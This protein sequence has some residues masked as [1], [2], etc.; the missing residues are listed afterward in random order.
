MRTGIGL[1][2]NSAPFDDWATNLTGAFSFSRYLL[3]S[4]TSSLYTD[5]G[6]GKIS[7]LN[8]QAGNARNFAQATAGN[9][10][11]LSTIGASSRA[12]ALFAASA[13]MNLA[14]AVAQSAF[15][16]STKAYIAVSGYYTTGTGGFPCR[17][18]GT[19]SGVVLCMTAVPNPFTAVYRGG[20]N[21]VANLSEPGSITFVLELRL[22]GGVLGARLNKGTWATVAC[23][24]ASDLTQ[25]MGIGYFY[26]SKVAELVCYNEVPSTTIQ[27]AIV[28]NMLAWIT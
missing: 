19:G 14:T 16:T 25:V 3:K 26:N 21:T 2:G 8:D 1:F 23:S 24:P 17:A 28:D 18:L 22:T 7:L 6:A 20:V 27:D 9:R 13:T 11:S 10:P 5:A 12:C 15:V 4:Y